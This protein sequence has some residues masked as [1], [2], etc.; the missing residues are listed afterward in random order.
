MEQNHPSLIKV[1]LIRANAPEAS[2]LRFDQS[3]KRVFRMKRGFV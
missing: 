2:D 1:S 3:F